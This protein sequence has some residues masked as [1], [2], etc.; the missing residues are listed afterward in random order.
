M[1]LGSLGSLSLCIFAHQFTVYDHCLD[2]TLLLFGHS[3]ILLFAGKQTLDCLSLDYPLS[4]TA[5][6]EQHG[7]LWTQWTRSKMLSICRGFPWGSKWIKS[8]PRT[9]VMRCST[10]MGKTWDDCRRCIVLKFPAPPGW[11]S[12]RPLRCIDSNIS[13]W[14]RWGTIGYQIGKN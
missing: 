6:T 11:P 14:N 12:M 10:V 2:C 13:D 9:K 5:L 4:L 3:W 1:L 8:P 7:Q